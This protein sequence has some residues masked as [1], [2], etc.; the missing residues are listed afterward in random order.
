MKLNARRGC[1]IMRRTPLCESMKINVDQKPSRV[2]NIL[3]RKCKQEDT[4]DKA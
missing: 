4:E 1:F 3:H 2:G